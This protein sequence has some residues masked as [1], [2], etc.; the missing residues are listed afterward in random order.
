[1]VTFETYMQGKRIHFPSDQ[2]NITLLKLVD[3]LGEFTIGTI[4]DTSGFVYR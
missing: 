3:F 2:E 4:Q 1:M